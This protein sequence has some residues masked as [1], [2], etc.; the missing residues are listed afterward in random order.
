MADKRSPSLL[1]R[2]DLME[3]ARHQLDGRIRD[4]QPDEIELDEV[5]QINRRPGAT[6]PD[7]FGYERTLAEQR[8][9]DPAAP[10]LGQQLMAHLLERERAMQRDPAYEF[11]AL[12]VGKAHNK[13]MTQFLDVQ[14]WDRE[15][16]AAVDAL[17]KRFD[18]RVDQAPEAKAKALALLQQYR[19]NLAL[20]S[21]TARDEVAQP[22]TRVLNELHLAEFGS[23]VPLDGARLGFMF[24]FYWRDQYVWLKRVLGEGDQPVSDA[25]LERMR[26]IVEYDQ[27]VLFPGRRTSLDI[28]VAG[29]PDKDDNLGRLKW[30]IACGLYVAQRDFFD[31]ETEAV[32][33]VTPLSQPKDASG[34]AFLAT[35]SYGEW[36]T[37]LMRQAVSYAVEA[38][39]ALAG[40]APQANELPIRSPITAD[41]QRDAVMFVPVADT[42][43]RPIHQRLDAKATMIDINELRQWLVPFAPITTL[44]AAG[45]PQPV[46]TLDEQAPV[47][48]VLGPPIRVDLVVYLN[49][50]GVGEEAISYTST[51]PFGFPGGSRYELA[52]RPP[53]AGPARVTLYNEALFANDVIAKGT[54]PGLVA[55]LDTL[56]Q[57]MNLTLLDPVLGLNNQSAGR[58]ALFPTLGMFNLACAVLNKA[59]SPVLLRIAQELAPTPSRRALRSF[60]FELPHRLAPLQPADVPEGSSLS[61][62]MQRRLLGVRPQDDPAVWL[63]PMNLATGDM[64][65]IAGE[66]M[67][68]LFMAPH[69]TFVGLGPSLAVELENARALGLQP[70]DDGNYISNMPAIDVVGTFYPTRR[71]ARRTTPKDR[72]ELDAPW[73]RFSASGWRRVLSPVWPDM[74]QE[75]VQVLPDQLLEDY[76]P[77]PY[78]TTRYLVETILP[79]LD[80]DFAVKWGN[81]LL[82]GEPLD[83]DTP[84]GRF[85]H[86]LRLPNAAAQDANRELFQRLDDIQRKMVAP[87]G[88]G[89][90]PVPKTRI[91]SSCPDLA[92]PRRPRPGR[93]I[94]SN[95]Y[96][97]S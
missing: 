54:N 83:W 13:P 11:W 87:V 44:D 34:R 60:Y 91:V 45:L 19:D 28:L 43:D 71:L 59:L 76:R 95:P 72:I 92:Q 58:R 82:Q 89:M 74:L 27:R 15:F 94:C 51:V 93:P 25:D 47:N 57:K 7:R 86:P 40:V 10:P 5:L 3:D 68:T 24:P 17:R 46:I 12:V 33:V 49:L 56:L 77:L 81:E 52:K 22:M 96:K 21:S 84:T 50:D 48:A 88:Y 53:G 31:R 30:R 90:S 61:Q 70:Q 35:N 6:Y 32:G 23:V 18:K 64:T 62:E 26:A 14:S 42:A 38:T 63:L 65:E 29:R 73:A 55:D 79:V 66:T 67:A 20:V 75:A 85:R 41:Q 4:D 2:L 16:Q 9:A 80:G 37:R 78:T 69:Q 39:A 8:V 1:H 36:L 97:R